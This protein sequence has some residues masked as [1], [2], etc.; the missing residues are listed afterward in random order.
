MLDTCRT[1]QIALNLKKCIFCMPF[2][3]F[4]DYVICKHGLM[5][6]PTKIAVNM[7]LE[8]PKNV[9]STH[10]SILDWKKEFHVHVDAS[11]IALGVAMTQ[12]GE[13]DIDHPIAF[14]SRKLSKSKKKL[15]HYKVK[16]FGDDLR[17]TKVSTLIVGRTF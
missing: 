15:F 1:Y 10:L 12:P 17:T 5:M 3:I 6:D 4:L 2:R 8:A 14:S 16:R 9:R 7:N 11:C 13:G